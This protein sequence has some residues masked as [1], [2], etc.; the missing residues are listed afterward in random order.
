MPDQPTPSI[1]ALA[2][3]L[4]GPLEPNGPR[5]GADSGSPQTATRVLHAS[6]DGTLVVGIWEC[7]PGGWS[8]VDRPDTEVIHLLAGRARITDADGTVHELGPGD[9]MILPRGWSG[10]WDISET[11]RKL[12][13][14]RTA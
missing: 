3:L 9:A 11:V 1:A 4:V 10:R 8:I 12:F 14:T 13:M 5:V 6:A 7:T 2:D